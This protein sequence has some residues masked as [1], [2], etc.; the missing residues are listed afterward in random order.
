[1]SDGPLCA[2]FCGATAFSTVLVRKRSFFRIEETATNWE[3][4]PNRSAVLY[5]LWQK[6]NT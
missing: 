5:Y 4:I 1:M 2:E 6:V 3:R